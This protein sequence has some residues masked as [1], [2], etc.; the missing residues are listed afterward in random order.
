[1]DCYACDQEAI[2]R[3]SRCGNLFCRDHGGDPSVGSGQ[4]LCADCLDPSNALPSGTVFR[5]S[6][7]ALL[8]ASVLALWLLVRP[9]S[10]PGESPQVSQPRPSPFSTPVLPSPSATPARGHTPTPVQPTP[11]PSPPPAFL[12]YVVKEGDTLTGIAQELAPAGVEPFAF[13][14]Q[15]A[16]ANG[17]DFTN[18][19]V[20]PGDVLVIPILPTAAP[21]PTPTPGVGP[22]PTSAAAHPSPSPTPTPTPSGPLTYPVVEGDT[23]LGIAQELAP[24]GV[25]PFAFAQQIAELN[26]ID[27]NNPLINPGQKLL[28]PQ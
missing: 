20:R 14:Q 9:P 12:E 11:S 17:I 1:M 13:A 23:L 18:P 27:F 25:E 16:A 6:I 3:C 4:A 22:T 26:G 2:E 28:I 21:T 24:A 8:L 19:L 15:I 5:G 10:L 7:L